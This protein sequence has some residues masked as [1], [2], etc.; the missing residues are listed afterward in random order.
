MVIAHC[1]DDFHGC[2]LEID[3]SIRGSVW[4]NFQ[5]VMM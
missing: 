1:V 2:W 4:V 5:L 3:Y